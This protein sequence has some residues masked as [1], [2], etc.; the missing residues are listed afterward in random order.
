MSL[1]KSWGIPVKVLPWEEQVKAELEENPGEW[2]CLGTVSGYHDSKVNAL[3]RIGVET[4]VFQ[5]DEYDYR[6]SWTTYTLY[7]RLPV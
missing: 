6:E 7:A 3:K 4:Q 5:T 2:G 1:V